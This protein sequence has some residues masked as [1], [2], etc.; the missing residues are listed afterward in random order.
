MNTC[1][2]II[3]AYNEALNLK[4]CL[5]SIFKTRP[6]SL[7]I[8]VIVVDNNSTDNT[9]Q[10]IKDIP[11]AVYLKEEKQGA[12]YARNTG[13]RRA[14][15]DILVFLDADTIVSE[16]WL[17][18]LLSPFEGHTVGAVGGGILPFSENNLVSEYLGISLFMRYPR[19]GAR[20]KIKGFPSCNLAVRKE[21]VREGFDTKIFTTYG[22]DKDLCFKI[23][24]AGFSVLFVPEALVLHQHPESFRSLASLLV[25]SSRGRMAFGKKH[26]FSPDIL[27]MNTHLPLMYLFLLLAC[28]F[29]GKYIFLSILI[30][31]ALLYFIYNSIL[32]YIKSRK[33]ILCFFIKP[34]LDTISL[35]IIY[36]F[37]TLFRIKGHF[38][39]K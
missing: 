26:A 21:L 28:L 32:F 19:Y 25:K 3:A 8:E 36:F 15:G 7:S 17:N 2:I 5:N 24:D 31:P 6:D 39:E 37:Y 34:L 4:L 29:A 12:S 11:Q 23:I 22:E 27:I 9:A 16:N 20:R 38:K 1:S 13:I 30:A 35:Y 14:S 18:N 33:F 10:I